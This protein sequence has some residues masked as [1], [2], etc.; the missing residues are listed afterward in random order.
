M[1]A[2][3]EVA[4]VN[5][6]R[7]NMLQLREDVTRFRYG[8]EQHL[9]EA[10]TRIFQFGRQKGIPR[11]LVALC[12][13]PKSVSA[14]TQCAA[15]LEAS[16]HNVRRSDPKLLPGLCLL[17]LGCDCHFMSFAHLE[18]VLFLVPKEAPL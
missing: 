6:D 15:L 11:R 4:N 7:G 18:P 13:V 12:E 14:V 17:L 2:F 8:D 9:D 10:L 1:L 16:L 5:T 3:H